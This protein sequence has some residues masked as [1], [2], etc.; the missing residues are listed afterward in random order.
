MAKISAHGQEL[1]R[2]LARR[3][4]GPAFCMLVCSDGTI[5][6][7]T[8]GAETWKLY[9][10]MK[11]GEDPQAFVDQRRS[12][13]FFGCS[14]PSYKALMR[15]STEGLCETPDGCLVEEDGKCTHGFP[16]WLKLAGW[17]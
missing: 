8:I 4:N 14:V 1:G 12:D 7:K 16:S 15:W 5:L 13:K 3:G 2:W 11:P 9:G 17:V 6:R 10:K